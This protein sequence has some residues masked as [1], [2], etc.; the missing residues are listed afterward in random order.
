[1]DYS[2][3]R[4][5]DGDMI[6]IDAVLDRFENKVEV[7]G[8]V[9]RAG[10]YQLNGEVN[11]VKQL[12]KKAEGLRGDAFLNRVLLD[13]ERED[14]THE[15]VAIDLN[16]LLNGSMADIPLRKNDHLYIP[17]IHD[18]KEEET[19]SI[20]GEVMNPGTFLHSD[21][22]AIEDLIIQAGGLT[23]AAATTRVSVTRRIKDAKSDS[24]STKL[25]DTFVFD[26]KDGLLMGTEDFSL[27]PF[28]V[29]QI[30]RSPAYQVQRTV[31]LAG[32][33][34][35][36]GSYTLLKKNERLSV[37]I[38]RAGG[39]TPEAYAKG[40]RLVRKRNE[41]ERRRE[42]DMLRIARNAEAEDS[43]AVDKLAIS[44]TYTV[45]ID[46]EKALANPGSDY[47]IVLREGDMIYIPEF[48]NTVKISGSVMYPNTVTWTKDAKLKYYIDMAGGYGENA[49]KKKAY[50]I[51]LN[52]TVSRVKKNNSTLI[53]PGCE[54]VVPSKKE[55]QGLKLADIM[56]MGS[57][58]ATIAAMVATLANSFK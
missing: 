46:L 26:I 48:I 2:V 15:V 14:Y 27:E 7:S 56:G 40:A 31:V 50:V 30:R 23:E 20:Y 28:D 16:Q 52:G 47:D 44:E 38:E 22:M 39:L 41:E 12:I 43:I 19:V 21:N 1:M 4:L 11:T 13:R 5:D 18:L 49:R 8:A 57:M 34:L 3:F 29:V 58:T 54:I 36:G 25:A 10:L 53:Q 24:F 42:M 6:T 35:F 9:Y 51:Y 32:E 55:R 33:V 45:G 17:S 37:L